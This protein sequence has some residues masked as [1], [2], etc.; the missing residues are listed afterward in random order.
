MIDWKIY[1]KIGGIVAKS[2]A[3]VQYKYIYFHD[4]RSHSHRY[5]KPKVR[6]ISIL[7]PKVNH[8]KREFIS[9][10]VQDS[11]LHT[12]SQHKDSIC[13]SITRLN[14]SNQP[15]SKPPSHRPGTQSTDIQRNYSIE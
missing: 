6:S 9:V 10:S 1:G 15:T 8:R 3:K 11:T 5:P 14:P 7:S 12:T 2:I 13:C 4:A